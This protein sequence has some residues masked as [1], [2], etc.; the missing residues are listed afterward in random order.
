LLALLLVL[1]FSLNLFLKATSCQCQVKP[2]LEDQRLSNINKDTQPL[3]YNDTQIIKCKREF[4][5]FHQDQNHVCEVVNIYIKNDTKE[6]IVYG[7][8]L[9][10]VLHIFSNEVH[11]IPEEIF[12]EFPS[13]KNLI[14]NGNHLQIIERTTFRA[15]KLLEVLRLSNNELVELNAHIFNM[16]YLKTLDLGRNRLERI[17]SEAFSGLVALERLY[18]S[19]NNLK[20]IP[21]DIFYPLPKLSFL[22]LENNQFTKLDDDI[23]KNNPQMKSLGLSNNSFTELKNEIF[24]YFNNLTDLSVSIEAFPFSLPH[25][26][27]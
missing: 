1:S 7:N 9:T 13:L 26:T 25:N 17:A 15:A 8:E 14:V 21:S 22:S 24:H 6:V 3:A 11:Y 2:N 4:F 10:T 18:L 12:K 23:F 5:L 20:T 27:T 19:D 16:Q